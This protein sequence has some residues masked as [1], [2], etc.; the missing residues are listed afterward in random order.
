ML[1]YPL[2]YIISPAALWGGGVGAGKGGGRGGGDGALGGQVVEFPL[3]GLS[4]L[5]L[6]GFFFFSRAE[7]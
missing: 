2:A 4:L 5:H 7:V 6:V 3:A 1:A